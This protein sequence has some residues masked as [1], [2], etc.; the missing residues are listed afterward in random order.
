MSEEKTQD[1]LDS[2][3]IDYVFEESNE[4]STRKLA[5]IQRITNLQPIPN[6][7]AIELATILG[8]KVVVKKGEHKV[9]DLVVYCEIDSVLPET[10][11][12]NFLSESK[13]RIKTKKMRGQISQ[14]ICFPISILNHYGSINSNNQFFTNV[15]ESDTILFSFTNFNIQEDVDVTELIGVKKYEVKESGSGGF[16]GGFRKG[17]FPYYIPKTDETRVQVL[18]KLIDE[19][20]GLP[21]YITEKLDGCSATYFMKDGVFGVCSRNREVKDDDTNVFWQMARK[22]DIENVL[23]EMCDNYVIQGEIIGPKIQGNKLQ[24]AENELRVFDVF[25]IDKQEYFN[26]EQY[27]NFIISA[28]EYELKS[29][30]FIENEFNLCSVDELVEMSIRKSLLNNNI[31]CEGI[32]IR[33][34]EHI[35]NDIILHK[36]GTNRLSCKAINP[37]FLLKYD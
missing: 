32:V 16:N 8:W 12:F 13:Y 20:K 31:E 1:E 27:T 14:G 25:D 26:Y 24:L 18:H 21:C 35:N 22:Y 7:D 36:M 6:A 9:N 15:V 10:E 37:K 19:H 30:P 11:W 3:L 28:Y 5:T 23:R 4:E 2:E 34:R 33:S 17:N 29:V